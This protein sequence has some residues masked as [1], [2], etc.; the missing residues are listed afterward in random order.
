[1]QDTSKKINYARLK[2]GITQ[3]FQCYNNPQ[4]KKQFNKDVKWI[5]GEDKDGNAVYGDTQLVTWEQVQELAEEASAKWALNKLREERD[6]RLA[7]TDWW[8][9]AD[10]TMT[11]A[12]TAYRQALRDITNT[13]QPELDW[14]DQLDLTSVDWP[15]KPQ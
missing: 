9:V 10:R 14:N 12:Q 15:I 1:M 8:A 5:V 11:P 3:D 13:A 7:E 2:L 4:T 6:R